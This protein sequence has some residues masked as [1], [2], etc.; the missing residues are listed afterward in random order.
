[1]I[2]CIH[3]T[4]ER[5]QKIWNNST[6]ISLYVSVK[7]ITQLRVEQG[8]FQRG[9]TA[10]ASVATL[11]HSHSSVQ[12]TWWW[13]IATVATVSFNTS[14]PTSHSVFNLQVQSFSLQFSKPTMPSCGWY[15]P[16]DVTVSHLGMG[17][18]GFNGAL[19]QATD[20]NCISHFVN[21]TSLPP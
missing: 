19:K 13:K 1:M 6:A 15:T 2:F 10:N 14:T 17:E 9:G 7:S 16:A 20:T 18:V 21:V 5:N 3:Q 8:A 12:P 4:Q 11:Y